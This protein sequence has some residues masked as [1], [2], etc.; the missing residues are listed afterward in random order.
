MTAYSC[1]C[2][3][4]TGKPPCTSTKSARYLMP[5][6]VNRPGK[7]NS[8]R[9]TPSVPRRQT[10]SCL[11]GTYNDRTCSVANSAQTLTAF[12]T[13]IGSSLDVQFGWLGGF[14]IHYALPIGSRTTTYQVSDDLVKTQG[15]HKFALGINFLRTDA[16]L[17]GYNRYGIGLLSPLSLSAFFCGGVSPSQDPTKISLTHP[18]LVDHP[19]Q[20]RIS[21]PP[22]IFPL[23]SW[24]R[25]P[26]TVSVSTA[27]RSGTPVPT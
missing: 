7:A 1:S 12:P 14:D 15:R 21:P 18:C 23:S 9:R 19:T 17:G 3:S 24:N 8:T 20:S 6:A 11:R 5:I 25:L 10:S 16:T 22:A 2:N 13:E 4:A 27:R 26:S